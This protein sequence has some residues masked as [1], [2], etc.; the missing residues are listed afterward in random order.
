MFPLMSILTA[1]PWR[2]I[3]VGAVISMLFVGGCQY[4]EKRGEQRVAARWEAEKTATAVAVAHQ[5]EQV[6]AVTAHQSIVNQEISNELQ[7]ANA[8]LAAERG[9]VL[10]RA[11]PAMAQRVRDDSATGGAGAM[12]EVSGATVRTDAATADPVPPAGQPEI[13]ATCE[14]LAEDAA[15][16]TLMLVEFQQWYQQQTGAFRN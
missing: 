14:K 10:E 11:S 15:K 16:T 3:G 1:L 5:A 9:H 13:S 7:K 8:A 6:A 4:G 2:F 12:P